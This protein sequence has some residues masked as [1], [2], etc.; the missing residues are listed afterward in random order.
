VKGNGITARRLLGISGFAQRKLDAYSALRLAITAGDRNVGVIEPACGAGA[1]CSTR[2]ARS[3][4]VTG[5]AAAGAKSLLPAVAPISSAG[6]CREEIFEEGHA[7]AMVAR[8]AP[9]REST[10]PPTEA[11][12]AAPTETQG[13]AGS[14]F[15]AR[16]VGNA[17]AEQGSEAACRVRPAAPGTRWTA[18]CGPN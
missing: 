3:Y 5:T 13:G 14:P 18:G 1:N 7:S 4:L 10:P 16:L 6:L 15:H 8:I 2:P 9:I 17:D 11:P 12:L